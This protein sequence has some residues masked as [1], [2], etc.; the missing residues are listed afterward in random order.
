MTYTINL[1]SHNDNHSDS[2]ETG[3]DWAELKLALVE[4]TT[5]VVGP[6]A[7]TVDDKLTADVMAVSEAGEYVFKRQYSNGDDDNSCTVYI[8]QDEVEF[9]ADDSVPYN[10]CVK[11]CD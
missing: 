7:V 11:W 6:N 8:T 5:K 1:I 4:M 10:D 2:E 3:L 9:S